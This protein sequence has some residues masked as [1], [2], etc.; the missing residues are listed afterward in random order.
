MIQKIFEKKGNHE[1]VFVCHL[2]G[3]ISVKKKTLKTAILLVQ[4][5]IK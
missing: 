3:Y 1:H 4:E 2:V 5:L